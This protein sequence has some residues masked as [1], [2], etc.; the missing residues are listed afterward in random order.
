[1]GKNQFRVRK[2]SKFMK[3]IFIG[4]IIGLFVANSFGQTTPVTVGQS[5][6]MK[7]AI[8]SEERKVL[9]ALPRDY[10]KGT[11][12]YPVIYV[13]DGEWNFPFVAEAVKVLADSERIPPSIVIGVTN[14]DRNRDFTT[15]LTTNFEKPDFMNKVGGANNFL[16]YLEKELVPLVDK[17]FRTAPYRTLIGHSLGGIFAWHSLA[18]R[19]QLFQSYLILDASVFWDN[20]AVVKE[21]KEFFKQNPT[22]KSRVFWGR[23]RIP[24]EVW[25][26]QNTE[27]LAFWEKNPPKNVRFK[28]YEMEDE[29]HS[30]L[31]F[32][33]S[34]IGLRTLYADYLI[35]YT[36]KM[37]LADVTNHYAA[38]SKEFGYEVRIPQGRITG[39]AGQFKTLK[40]FKDAIALYQI[41]LKSYPPSLEML[42]GLAEAYEADNQQKTALETYQKADALT[43]EQSETQR[44]NRKAKIESLKKQLNLK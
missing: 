12:K 1:M 14:S 34:Y 6:T 4:L 37:T 9:V 5:F 10:E 42:D 2:Q 27:F 43:E 41:G 7:S 28:F 36:E 16:N 40:M 21:V 15:K 3:I 13:L 19:P 11:Q 44:A 8:L 18:S 39:V 24:R 25:F 35:P 26:T 30:T 32:P 22:A 33:G 31:V 38:L 23:D 29:T 20:G 17:T